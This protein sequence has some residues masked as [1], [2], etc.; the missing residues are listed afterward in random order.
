MEPSGR[1]AILMPSSMLSCSEPKSKTC[2]ICARFLDKYFISLNA[3][4]RRAFL[5]FELSRDRAQVFL[6]FQKQNLFTTPTQ[7]EMNKRQCSHKQ[8]LNYPLPAPLRA[9]SQN[10][11]RKRSEGMP[12]TLCPAVKCLRCRANVKYVCRL[13]NARN[14]CTSCKREMLPSATLRKRAVIALILLRHRT[15]PKNGPRKRGEGKPT[16]NDSSFCCRLFVG[17]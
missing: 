7:P 8:L 6:Y 11:P 1:R 17:A 14:A 2:K 13:A 10:R 5:S 9:K 15:K 12:D 4:L 16:K 3:F